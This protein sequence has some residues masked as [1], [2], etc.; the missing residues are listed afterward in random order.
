MGAVGAAA[1]HLAG[2]VIVGAESLYAGVWP[3]AILVARMSVFTLSAGG[4]V[5]LLTAGAIGVGAHWSRSITKGRAFALGLPFGAV[6]G[7]AL[8]MAAAR[9]PVGALLVNAIVFGLGTGVLGATAVALAEQADEGPAL[10]S[11]LRLEELPG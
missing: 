3:S 10:E 7:L 5:G 8:S 4:F 11:G 2:W 1:F 9:L 6:G